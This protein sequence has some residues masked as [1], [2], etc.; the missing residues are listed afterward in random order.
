MADSR[1]LAANRMQV[2]Q[3]LNSEHRKLRDT[4]WEL[5][6]KHAPSAR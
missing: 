2:Q 1:M 3:V 4:L 5:L 6:V